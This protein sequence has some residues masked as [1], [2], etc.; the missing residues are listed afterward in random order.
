MAD[1]KG[2]VVIVTGGAL[3]IGAGTALEFARNG[4]SVTI[5]DIN[6]TA[7]HQVRCELDLA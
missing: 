7:R 3:G 4:A 2:K 6:I 5:A 1:F